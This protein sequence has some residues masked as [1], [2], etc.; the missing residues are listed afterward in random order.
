MSGFNSRDVFVGWPQ[1]LIGLAL[2]V[3][4]GVGLA[5]C[6]DADGVAETTATA[7]ASTEAAATISTAAVTTATATASTEA[8]ATITT[9]SE[10]STTSSVASSGEVSESDRAAINDVLTASAAA[11]GAGDASAFVALWTDRGLEQ[12]GLGTRGRRSSPMGSIARSGPANRSAN[13]SSRF[14]VTTLR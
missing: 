10:P 7:T 4:L 14:P 1:A 9:A 3:L 5:A 2:V 8:A 13:R 12:Y 6:G 11:E